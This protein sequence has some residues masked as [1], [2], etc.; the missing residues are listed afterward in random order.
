MEVTGSSKVMPPSC[1]L[2]CGVPVGIMIAI[3]S[4]SLWMDESSGKSCL[5][6]IAVEVIC[7]VSTDSRFTEPPPKEMLPLKIPPDAESKLLVN[8]LTWYW[9]N[10]MS[11]AHRTSKDIITAFVVFLSIYPLLAIGHII[12]NDPL[13]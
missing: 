11:N 13:K 5:T 8:A 4:S 7:A 3:A 12:G 2:Y 1:A 9:L 10:A 6:A